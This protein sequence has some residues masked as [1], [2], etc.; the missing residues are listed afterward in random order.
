MKKPFGLQWNEELFADIDSLER[1]GQDNVE[2]RKIHQE[3]VDAQKNLDETCQRGH[4]LDRA[5]RV[6]PA[7]HHRQATVGALNKVHLLFGRGSAVPRVCR[8]SAPY[9]AA[10][11]LIQ[12]G[13]QGRRS[14]F[15]VGARK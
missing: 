5:G 12:L 14:L 10:S 4:G 8:R 7:G 2:L 11:P 15:T 3:L 9:L 1:K 6:R 13:K